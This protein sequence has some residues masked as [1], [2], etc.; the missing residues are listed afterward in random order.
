MISFTHARGTPVAAGSA[1][2]PVRY[3]PVS[4]REYRSGWH[5]VRDFVPGAPGLRATPALVG[6]TAHSE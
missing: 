5:R 2:S 6:S 4:L 3:W 1:K